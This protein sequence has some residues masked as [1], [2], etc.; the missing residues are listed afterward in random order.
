MKTFRITP[1]R[2]V[3]HVKRCAPKVV[4]KILPAVIYDI[5]IEHHQ[6]SFEEV[7]KVVLDTVA[8]EAISKC[9]NFLLHNIK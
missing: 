4:N 2:V 6:V 5:G 7:H 3:V 9:S 1:L 8:V